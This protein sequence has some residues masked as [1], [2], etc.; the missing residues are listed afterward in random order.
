MILN[1]HNR[2]DRVLIVLKTR[3]ENYVT[4]RIDVVYAEN[5]IVLP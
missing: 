1:C 2:S 4:H 3:L 5:K